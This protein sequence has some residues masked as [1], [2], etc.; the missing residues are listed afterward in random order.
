[1]QNLPKM[2]SFTLKPTQTIA[3]LMPSHTGNVIIKASTGA[4][5]TWFVLNHLMPKHH[6]V[7]LCPT[8]AQVKQCEDT[9]A[10]AYNC[11][12]IHGEKSISPTQYKMLSRQNLVMTFDQ[13]AK[14]RKHLNR[15]TIL[16]VDEAQKLY[17][18]GHYREKAIQP[19]I[20][21]LVER[22]YEKAFLL[23]AT[24]TEYIFEQ[25]N[26]HISQHL[27]FQTATPIHRHIQIINYTYPDRLQWY[28]YVLTRLEKNK[29]AGE[30][31][32]I[33]VRLNDITFCKQVRLMFEQEGFDV[34]LVNRHEMQ[35][36]DCREMLKHEKLNK[37]YQVVLCSSV[38]DEAINLNNPD[39]EVDSIHFVGQHAHPEEITQF[40]GR[41]RKANPPIYIHLPSMTAKGNSKTCP[42]M[43]ENLVNKMLRELGATIHF[44]D[45]SLRPMLS[46]KQFEAMGDF[47]RGNINIVKSLNA[48]TSEVLG[49]NG[50][51]APN[52]DSIILNYAS[53]TARLYLID[54]INTYTDIAYLS[55]RLKQYIPD[56]SITTKTCDSKISSQLAA[57]LTQS[58]KDLQQSKVH[59]IEQ[60]KADIIADM[61]DASSFPIQRHLELYHSDQSNPY[62]ATMMEAEHQVFND[63]VGLRKILTNIEDMGDA[64]KNERVS[65]VLN[66]NHQYQHHPIVKPMMDELSKAFK[67]PEFLSVRHTYADITKIMNRW[68]ARVAKSHPITKLLRE[69]PLSY[70]ESH[71]QSTVTFNEGGSIRF[72]KKYSYIKVFNDKKPIEQKKIQF[73]G[74]AAYNYQYYVLPESQNSI[75]YTMVQGV[76][77]NA[78]T[79]RK[80][81]KNNKNGGFIEA[82]LD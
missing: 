43:H 65:K 23:T 44:L 5:K 80:Q 75:R 79:G 9:Y 32:L 37:K 39:D 10:D 74:L 17:S 52:D 30:E 59:A 51:W 69:Y 48:Y 21:D 35:N 11:H 49:C 67:Q 12:F 36:I 77:Y 58:K 78:C 16:V 81:D 47:V 55:Y 57:Q 15:N 1:M 64:I 38:L 70:L 63:M 28:P 14:F 29:R 82:E 56:L 13:Y 7:L 6:V 72:L 73:L 50:F 8:V 25:L 40:I 41:M 66:I 31:K 22:R 42:K 61:N 34:M 62:D 54:T 71:S 2:R 18:V 4:G 33:I 20:T 3:Q 60:V 68:L 46:T 27:E 19:I 24:F 53:F 26:I 45:Y 76:K